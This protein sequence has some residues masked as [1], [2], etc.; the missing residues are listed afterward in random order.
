MS[1]SPEVLVAFENWKCSE[2]AARYAEPCPQE[3]M[4]HL[5]D[6]ESQLF[7][8]LMDLPAANADD[9]LLK[10]YPVMLRE[11][12][13]KRDAPPL[14]LGESR[15]YG[16]DTSFY[17]QLIE[18]LGAVSSPIAAASSVLPIAAGRQEASA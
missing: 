7:D 1:A 2:L 15:S 8:D 14:R 4:E 9:M 3:V 6:A 11:F 18:H 16:Y 17:E 13:P 5:V 10:L 12:E